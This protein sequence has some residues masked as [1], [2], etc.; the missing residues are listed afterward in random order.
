MKNRSV[1]KNYFKKGDKPTQNS[2]FAGFLK[3][4]FTLTA[5]ITSQVQGI[6]LQ[7]TQ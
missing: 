6:D 3:V 1:L 4:L 2:N 7:Q 5:G